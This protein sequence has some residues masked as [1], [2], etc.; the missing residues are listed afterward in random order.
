MLAVLQVLQVL[1]LLDQP[2]PYAVL[3]T[4]SGGQ[5]GP[6]RRGLRVAATPSV[7]HHSGT[8]GGRVKLAF[9]FKATGNCG[10][11]F[12][13]PGSHTLRSFTILNPGRLPIC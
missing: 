2:K 13:I 8:P 11:D 5:P 3:R 9:D 12:Q 6:S 10:P 1:L 4:V 7:S